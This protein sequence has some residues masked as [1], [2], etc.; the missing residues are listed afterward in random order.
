MA[1]WEVIGALLL[2]ASKYLI[3]EII[4]RGSK[5]ILEWMFSDN[6]KKLIKAPPYKED[7][8]TMN[9]TKNMNEI[10]TNVRTEF[11][12]KV[13]ETEQGCVK[14]AEK[15]FSD[16]LNNISELDSQ[17]GCN[18][19]RNYLIKLFNDYISDLQGSL[20]ENI[21]K[22]LTISDKECNKILQLTGDKKETEMEKYIF[23]ILSEGIDKYIV[24]YR[25][26]INDAIEIITHSI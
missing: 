13:S 9:E 23:K 2:E 12:T 4:V 22:R 7:K 14:H 1:F 21:N 19:N 16:I 17:F 20:A 26:V 25:R 8:A 11:K 10:L 5:K 15:H 24:D 18:I 6:T 3:E